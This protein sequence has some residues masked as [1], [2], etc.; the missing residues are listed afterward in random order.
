MIHIIRERATDEQ[1][2]DMLEALQTYLKLAVDVRRRVVAGGGA[3]HADC[4]AALLEDGSQQADVWGADWI[5]ES[6]EVRFESLI[7]IRPKQGNRTMTIEAPALR[8]TIAQI[9]R[10]RF[11]A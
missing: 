5:P 8:Q 10:E 2:R 3:L 11:Q 7:N 1:I 6:R 9:V 4:E